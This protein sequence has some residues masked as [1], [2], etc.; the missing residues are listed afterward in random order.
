MPDMQPRGAQAT[1]VV[2][3]RGRFH[4]AP[5]N[6]NIVM[7]DQPGPYECLAVL[8]EGPSVRLYGVQTPTAQTVFER[9]RGYYAEND[10]ASALELEELFIRH[11]IPADR[12]LT[13]APEL[14]E[15]LGKI[16]DAELKLRVYFLE[17]FVEIKPIIAAKPNFDLAESLINDV[18]LVEKRRG[19]ELKDVNSE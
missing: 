11:K 18:N 4:L 7:W 2:D 19:V 13:L 5:R 10:I 14:L 16:P 6:L 17:D 8:L 15:H 1:E 3:D 9:Y 12:R